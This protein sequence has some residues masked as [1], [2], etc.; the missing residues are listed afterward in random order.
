MLTAQLSWCNFDLQWEQKPL[1]F[2]CT[3]QSVIQLQNGS[4]ALKTGHILSSLT[5]FSSPEVL[6]KTRKQNY[7]LV[8]PGAADSQ[9]KRAEVEGTT[10]SHSQN[11][12]VFLWW[13]GM[14]LQREI[15]FSKLWTWCKFAG[16]IRDLSN[17]LLGRST[18]QSISMR[19]SWVRRRWFSKPFHGNL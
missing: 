18:Q 17:H 13:Y 4:S 1:V 15:E 7:L 8:K 2:I 3:I 10:R 14:H 11:G 9:Q 16:D 5:F 19:I 12:A 6:R